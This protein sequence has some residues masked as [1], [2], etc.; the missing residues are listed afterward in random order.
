MR[1]KPF[2]SSI[3]PKSTRIGMLIFS[4]VCGP[5]QVKSLGGAR[6]YLLFR[7]EY[8]NFR[9]VHFIKQKSE[10]LEH[11][12]TF[13]ALLHTQT[14][15][16][17]TEFRSDGGTEYL[18]LDSWLNSI[19]I[20]HQTTCRYSPQQNAIERDNRTVVQLVHAL[21]Y[22]NTNIPLTLWAEAT[23]CIV[24][25]LNRV[26]SS[27]N[28]TKTPFELWYGRKP[29]VSNLRAFESEFCVLILS[30]LCQKL[31]VKAHLC[32][33]VGNSD[34]QKEDRYWDPSTGK[35]NVSRDV[36]P[37]DHY[38]TPRLPT[39]DIQM[40]GDDVFSTCETSETKYPTTRRKLLSIK[41]R[42]D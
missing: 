22:S 35:V 1:R 32:I 28:L 9:A 34:T 2:Q 14:G 23:S 20:R 41:L 21:L 7:D 25:T 15:E 31:D 27:A 18:L 19:E 3:C 8:S 6:Y 13:I 12:K 16:L 33:F 37:I 40:G 42:I 30:Q 38:Y 10:V 17:V 26:L 4:D 36:S 11:C 39:T 24:Y 5:I 29:D